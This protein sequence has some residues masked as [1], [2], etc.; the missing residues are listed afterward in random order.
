MVD[1]PFMSRD[2][3]K[4][5]HS[6]NPNIRQT[7]VNG[8]GGFAFKDIADRREMQE[9]IRDNPLIQK[10]DD[11]IKQI[12]R[13]KSVIE[14]ED[15]EKISSPPS[16]N[17]KFS[18]KEDS[19]EILGELNNISTTNELL[20]LNR[21]EAQEIIKEL[22]IDHLPD[23]IKN[24]MVKVELDRRNSIPKETLTEEPTQKKIISNIDPNTPV[25]PPAISRAQ[26]RKQIEK[27]ISDKY[28]ANVPLIDEPKI[29]PRINIGKPNITGKYSKVE[30]LSGYA[31]YDFNSC[32]VRKFN[33]YDV[34]KIRNAKVE[35]NVSDFIDAV[36]ASLLEVDIRDL[37]IFDFKYLL[38]YH[39]LTSFT[40][41]PLII[42][43]S[44]KYGNDNVYKINERSLK[45]VI[46]KMTKEEFKD[47][48]ASKGICHP[49]VRDWELLQN[50]QFE[51]EDLYLINKAVYFKC[52]KGYSLQDKIDAMTKACEEDL[53]TLELI[54]QFNIDSE[55]YVNE[56]LDLTDAKFDP[57]DYLSILRTQAELL[58]GEKSQLD[59]SELNNI[60]QIQRINDQLLDINLEIDDIQ[61]K[62]ERK[63]AVL[64]DIETKTLDIKI[65]QF[66]P[67]I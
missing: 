45:Y 22:K 58:E 64:P 55:H 36:G 38:Y 29:L 6:D 53:S 61:G 54:D 28:K 11:E 42:N 3:S 5:P 41:T 30:F 27:E 17:N 66:F 34:P 40:A 47:K 21:P 16:I 25:E 48:Y 62:L 26:L 60:S 13:Q 63:E 44:S 52:D 59:A 4:L 15:E 32:E 18:N 2:N 35:E 23:Y 33:I 9:F 67:F 46:N 8:T 19:K 24:R 56:S 43:W 57:I 49:T 20:D 7:V 37:T 50:E 65:L 12:S 51:P 39:Q 1:N 14:Y 31:F 10:Q